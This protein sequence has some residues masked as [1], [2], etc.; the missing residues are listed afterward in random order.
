MPAIWRFIVWG[1]LLRAD[2]GCVEEWQITDSDG[3]ED[4]SLTAL[5]RPSGNPNV[6]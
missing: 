4:N 2:W 5:D 3:S 1:E 6:A